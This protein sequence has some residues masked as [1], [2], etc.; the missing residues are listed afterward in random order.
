MSRLPSVVLFAMLIIPAAGAATIQVNAGPCQ[1]GDVVFGSG[2]GQN[3]FSCAL[4]SLLFDD[5][6]AF[7]YEPPGVPIQFHITGVN[8]VGTETTITFNPIQPEFD[9]AVGREMFF[10]YRVRAQPG[11]APIN[12]IGLNIGG[13]NANV[14]ELACTTPVLTVFRTAIAY[15][16]GPGDFSP[17]NEIARLRNSSGNPS[18]KSGFFNPEGQVYVLKQINGP[19]VA[20]VLPE[21]SQRFNQVPEPASVLLMVSGLFCILR[22]RRSRFC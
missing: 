10:S 19:G 6:N 5:F 11:A 20:G 18:V 13:A 15:G 4:G 16:C 17:E 8:R 22:W 7:S 12:Q 9:P 1:S 3:A 21:I 2:V 14:T